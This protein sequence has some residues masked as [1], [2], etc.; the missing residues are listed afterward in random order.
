MRAVNSLPDPGGPDMRTRLLAGATFFSAWRNWRMVT[1]LPIISVSTPALPRSSSF[2]RLRRE[3][4]SARPT[5]RISRSALNGF[6][7]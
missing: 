5:T 2:S 7:I 1:E 4:S 3:A 6:S